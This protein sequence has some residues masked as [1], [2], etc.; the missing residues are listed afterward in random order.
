MYFFVTF[1][2]CRQ[3]CQPASG[4]KNMNATD[5]M[6]MTELSL[7]EME[8][9]SGGFW[10]WVIAAV[11]IFVGF[12]VSGSDAS[13]NKSGPY[14]SSDKAADEGGLTANNFSGD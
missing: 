3:F 7:E 14:G 4:V 9:V 8:K 10:S 13:A 5:T 12:S 11:V 2:T 6:G 1:V